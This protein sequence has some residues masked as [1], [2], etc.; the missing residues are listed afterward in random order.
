M[1]ERPEAAAANGPAAAGGPLATGTA[2]ATRASATAGTAVVDAPLLSL[3]GVSKRFGAVQALTDVDLDVS[4]GMVTALAGDNG[5]GKSVTIKTISG[6]WRPDGGR[7][8]WRGSQVD[9]AD[10]DAAA[11]LGITTVYQDLALCDNLDIVQNMFLGHEV[12]RGR[13]LDEDTMEKR[14]R[15]TLADLSVTTIRSVRQLVGSLSG[16]QRQSVAVAK[17]VMANSKLVILDEPT[18][19]LGVAQTRMVLDL[20]RRL[21]DRGVAVMLVS[22]NLND[23]FAVADRVAVL[24][25]GHMVVQAPVADLDTQMVV[26]Y[27]TLGR[28]DRVPTPANGSSARGSSAG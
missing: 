27:M 18:A 11:D 3:R 24:Y 23:V 15:S 14:A 4:E 28:S 2:P 19:A 10:P 1:D 5:A 16:G 7:I 25:L 26:D 8:L 20:V 21:A 22:H 6:L 9:I 17:A 13:T 12:L